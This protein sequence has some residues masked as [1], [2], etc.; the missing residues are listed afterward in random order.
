MAKSKLKPIHLKRDNVYCVTVLC[1]RNDKDIW[2]KG[3]IST[4]TKYIEAIKESYL[5]KKCLKA[6]NRRTDNEAM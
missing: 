4:A 3:G 1:G 5:C 6:K 2:D